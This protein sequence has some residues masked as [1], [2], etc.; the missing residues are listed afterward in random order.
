MPLLYL[1]ERRLTTGVN[2]QLVTDTDGVT[3]IGIRVFW[4]V[5]PQYITCQ[6]R[7]LRTH[8]FT[9]PNVHELYSMILAHGTSSH[10]YNDGDLLCNEHYQTRI[11]YSLGNIGV[12][13]QNQQLR[14]FYGSRY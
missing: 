2:A 10:V 1:A 3:L 13:D 12:S 7:N 9:S 6:Y 4:T 8:L 14:L 11:T 5:K